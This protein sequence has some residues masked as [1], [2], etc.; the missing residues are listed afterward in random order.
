MLPADERK[1]ELWYEAAGLESVPRLL[2]IDRQGILRADCGPDQLEQEITRELS[3]RWL[4]RLCSLWHARERT[5]QLG[6]PR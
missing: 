2:L 6:I 4:M 1:R 5:R 3:T